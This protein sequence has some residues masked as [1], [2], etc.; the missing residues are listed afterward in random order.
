MKKIFIIED[1]TIL[2][3]MLERIFVAEDFVVESALD[4]A[5]G[6]AKLYMMNEWPEA[7]LLD[8]MIP[9]LSGIEVLKLIK[10]SDRLKSIPVVI[11]SNLTPQPESEAKIVA[12]GAEIYLHKTDYTP[13]LVAKKV[14]E[15]IA[16]VAAAS[17]AQKIDADLV[18]FPPLPSIS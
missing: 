8:I 9:I 7:I 17:N 13:Q 6:L 5:D 11:L 10:N 1:D 12:L 3:R 15:I 18:P 14:I 2:L 4:G 16:S